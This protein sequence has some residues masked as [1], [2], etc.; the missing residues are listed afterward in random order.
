MLD[1]DDKTPAFLQNYGNTHQVECAALLRAMASG[2]A[3]GRRRLVSS[4]DIR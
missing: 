1:M 3:R 2:H 4:G